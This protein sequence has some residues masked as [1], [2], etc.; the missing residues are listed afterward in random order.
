MRP[1][2]ARLLLVAIVAGCTPVVSPSP[3]STTV[4]SPSASA[5]VQVSAS[6]LTLAD[7]KGCPVTKPGN[8]PVDIGDRLFGAGSAFGNSDLWVGG[9]G[10]DGVILADPRFVEQDGSIGWKLGWWRIVSGT[11]TITGRRLDAQAP[12]LPASAPEGY[13]Q[14]GFQASGVFFPTEGCWEVT[15]LVGSSTLALVTF[16]LRTP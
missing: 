2:L 3:S 11:L 7:A 15:G 13:G 4:A 6:P 8:A 1:V 10:A 5:T 9:L 16:V 12:P 14:S